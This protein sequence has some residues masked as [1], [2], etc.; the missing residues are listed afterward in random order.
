MD[1]FYNSFQVYPRS[2]SCS[3]EQQFQQWSIQLSI[4]QPWTYLSFT[5]CSLVFS[6]FASHLQSPL[7]LYS[8]HFQSEILPHPCYW[9]IAETQLV[10]SVHPHP[11]SCSIHTPNHTHPP[12]LN[13]VSI[14][15]NWFSYQKPPYFASNYRL[16]TNLARINLFGG[17][18][19]YY[20][21]FCHMIISWRNDC[22]E[23]AI[24]HHCLN[25][26]SSFLLI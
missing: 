13:C 12:L 4:L 15:L 7:S 1:L 22:E 18:H 6:W 5:F 8:L 11:P 10:T 2:N 26:R 24:L 9:V 3:L 14:L 23:G 25:Y 16:L 20:Y 19:T 21:H 17:F